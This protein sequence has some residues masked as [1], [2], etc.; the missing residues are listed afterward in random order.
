MRNPPNRIDD[1]TLFQDD[2][3]SYLNNHRGGFFRF[4]NGG[5]NYGDIEDTDY[6]YDQQ[7]GQQQQ[8]Q[9]QQYQQQQYQQPNQ[10]Y[11][12]QQNQPQYQQPQQ[13]QTQNIP[14]LDL[15]TLSSLAEAINQGG[16]INLSNLG[17][18][19]G[20]L[21]NLASL[22]SALGAVTGGGAGSTAA[23]P[24]KQST[25]SNL[26]ANLSLLSGL[27]SQL[28]LGDTVSNLLS[29]LVG[30][31]FKGRRARKLSKRSAEFTESSIPDDSLD[32]LL[33]TLGKD[34]NVE[35]GESTEPPSKKRNLNKEIGD[36]AT[37]MDNAEKLSWLKRKKYHQD[38]EKKEKIR[39]VEKI[40]GVQARII[41]KKEI[42]AEA[43]ARIVNGNGNF[44]LN[45]DSL[46]LNPI[47]FPDDYATPNSVNLT[48]LPGQ[49][50]FFPTHSQ[51]TRTGHHL[52]HSFVFPHGL[53][54]QLDD[55]R[56]GKAFQF[57]HSTVQSVPS[58]VPYNPL[59]FPETFQNN[60]GI[61]LDIPKPLPLE[62]YDHTKMIFPDR[63]GTGNLRFDNEELFQNQKKHLLGQNLIRIGR[64][65]TGA[66]Q[67][68][69]VSYQGSYNANHG[70][71]AANFNRGDVLVFHNNREDYQ[72]NNFGQRP[73]YDFGN[74][75]PLSDNVNNNRY[76]G[77]GG[78]GLTY[79]RPSSSSTDYYGDRNRYQ[80]TSSSSS[81]SNQN[82]GGKVYVTNAQGIV[83]YY[84]NERGE[85]IAV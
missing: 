64:I 18:N 36:D 19:L 14:G 57:S 16:G 53:R 65:L 39:Q 50:L 33:L 13:P 60:D 34:A 7:Q 68:R 21:G 40:L 11:Q 41:N 48:P 44:A 5:A 51:D 25:T 31:R 75:Y 28:G 54:Q 56:G 9:Q 2:V 45:T 15:G 58:N 66:N 42:E 77:G 70:S 79:N 17:S 72:N 81:S 69:P 27:G 37:Q 52:G 49:G 23:V 71:S 43:D 6:G 82:N 26:G 22:G 76:Q 30:Q 12:Q 78:G 24:Q 80:S 83:T 1:F 62:Y 32:E 38:E 8:Y 46:L 4:F 67:N 47:I 3:L 35:D 59:Q 61:I 73:Q 63:T 20:L 84:L 10:Q 85:K 29:G 74:R 55:N